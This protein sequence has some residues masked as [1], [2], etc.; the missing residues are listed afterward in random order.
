MLPSPH[1]MEELIYVN[2][3]ENESLGPI[4][5]ALVE[6][7]AN[8]KK[9]DL[10]TWRSPS[11]VPALLQLAESCHVEDLTIY[12]YNQDDVGLFSSALREGKLGLRSLTVMV[13]ARCKALH[14]ALQTYLEGETCALRRLDVSDFSEAM[15][16]EDFDLLIKAARKSLLTR[17]NLERFGHRKGSTLP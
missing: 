7:K 16:Q 14:A 10:S 13:G 12:L 11:A 8:V 5:R 4:L 1:H 9:V 17:L 2:C 3:G 6:I 15:S